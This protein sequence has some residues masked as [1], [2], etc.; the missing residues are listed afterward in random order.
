MSRKAHGSFNF[1]LHTLSFILLFLL[2]YPLI[3]LTLKPGYAQETFYKGQTIRIIVGF[4][5]VG[6]YDRWGRLFAR[7]MG[8]HIPGN[9]EIIVQNMPGASSVIAANHVYNVAKPD[10]LTLVMPINTLYLDQ[11]VG[12]Q[13]V[14]YDVRKFQ[15]IG[16][17]EKIVTML[18]A[19]AD[20]P[21]K[22]LADIIKAKEP[23]KC[24]ATGTASTG[25]I[26]PKILEETLGAKFNIVTGYPG[27][28]EIDIAVERGEITCRGMDISPH[29]GREPFDTWHVK[30]FDRH[31]VQDQRKKDP[32]LSDTP[33]IHELMDERKTPEASRRTAEVILASGLFGR[34]MAVT[35][36][37]PPERVKILREAY[38]KMMKDPELIAEAKKG[39][40]DMDPT[41]GEELQALAQQVMDQPKDVLERVKKIL[42]E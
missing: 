13:E 38:V 35:P 6:F 33:T 24:G 36:G 12:R 19:R 22:S 8:K 32:R 17:Q 42:S 18:Y 3:P 40:M 14:K 2:V 37:T 20:A 29:F 11:F 34:A 27:G 10:G 21:Y 4:T 25:Y 1:S 16:S 23:P 26:L 41:S 7:Y 9:P 39:R 31:L 28:N 15:W 5:P 30:G